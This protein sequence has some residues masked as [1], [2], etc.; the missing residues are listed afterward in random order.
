M[1][2]TDGPT[3]NSTEDQSDG[4][5]TAPSGTPVVT[6]ATNEDR[7][8]EILFSPFSHFSCVSI[9]IISFADLIENMINKYV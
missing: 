7:L 3:V 6:E 8:G 4:N 9:F 5:S 2:D 1:D